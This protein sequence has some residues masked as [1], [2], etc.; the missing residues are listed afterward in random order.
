LAFV[1]ECERILVKYLK[2]LYGERN[3]SAWTH[4]KET[5][6]HI[7]EYAGEKVILLRVPTAG[8]KTESVLIP[9][10]YQYIFDNWFLAPGLIYVLPNK[11]LLFSQYQRIV[12]MRDIICPNSKINVVADLGGIYPGKT[13]LF[14]DIVLTTLDAFAYGFMA[15]RTILLSKDENLGKTLFP[16]GNIATS[17]VVFD[18]VQ[19]YQDSSYYTPRILGKIINI[20]YES[21]IPVIIMTATM[22][23]IL[24]EN[25]IPETI[26]YVSIYNPKV[27]RGKV[28]IHLKTDTKL[29]D[30]VTFDLEFKDILCNYRR[31]LIVAN[32]V[33]R[34][35]QIYRA[36]R[37]IVEPLQFEI[38]LIHGR[39]LE[40]TRRRRESK[41]ENLK[42]SDTKY[43]L[44]ATQ[45]AESG[46][47]LDFQ[48]VL[49][50]LA[51]IDGLIQRLGRAARRISEGIGYIFGVES[52]K[53]YSKDI[54]DKTLNTLESSRLE[55]ALGN[56][57]DTDM[58]LNQVFTD[59]PPLPKHL[60]GIYN[61][62][63]G[64]IESLSPFI[65]FSCLR[66]QVR[67]ELYITILILEN[68]N[69]EE[70]K[71][72]EEFAELHLPYA[73]IRDNHMNVQYT[74]SDLER[75]PYLKFDDFALRVDLERSFLS[76]N[77]I[78]LKIS[79]AQKIFPQNLYLANPNYYAEEKDYDLGLVFKGEENV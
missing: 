7:Y 10:F 61:K 5:W 21:S 24:E 3:Y 70:L 17:M 58:L 42:N 40:A 74:G 25:L 62:T 19:M 13:F 45:V 76:N 50:E 41:L 79:M 71:K 15:K 54:L 67:P 29:L 16:I 33:S 27:K 57:R 53:P 36:L 60:I 66:A 32:A 49:T 9:Y 52:I 30:F 64:S 46:L 72:A 11:T 69:W 35:I 56:L 75:Y 47:D 34:A 38:D 44:V 78:L 48:V 18:E 12:K 68:I 26:D 43:I 65:D 4:Q 20:L 59:M 63:K 23:K 2:T 39:L 37:T 77:Y 6:R 51:P 1:K 55:A 8:G 28:S 22:P 14:G 73:V 31:I